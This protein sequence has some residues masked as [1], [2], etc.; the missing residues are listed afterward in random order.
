[1]RPT[2][3]IKNM[4]SSWRYR[5][6]FFLFYK[7]INISNKFVFK[8]FFL[9]GYF[10]LSWNE[11]SPRRTLTAR[12]RLQIQVPLFLLFL[13]F[14]K[15]LREVRK[16]F[17]NAAVLL[18]ENHELWLFE[19]LCLLPWKRKETFHMYENNY[20]WP[21]LLPKRDKGTDLGYLLSLKK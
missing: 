14:S 21:N 3:L 6:S 5:F 17:Q 8:R 10:S 19:Q 18:V 11:D 16:T 12:H 13:F 7:I 2:L 15:V 1:M 20:W 4:F 9:F